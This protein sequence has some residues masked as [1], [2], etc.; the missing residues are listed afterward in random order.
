[1][2]IIH[3]FCV[4]P[5]SDSKPPFFVSLF[6]KLQREKQ[7][8]LIVCRETPSFVL[9]SL[10]QKPFF[11]SYFFLFFVFC[12]YLSQSKGKTAKALYDYQAGKKLFAL[13]S[14]FVL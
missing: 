11:S 14:F 2:T 8:Y 6:S 9:L 13:E 5:L 4:L 3:C 7:K 12:L 1:M 10:P